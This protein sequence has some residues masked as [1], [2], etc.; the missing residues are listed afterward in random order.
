[1]HVRKVY[2]A[3]CSIILMEKLIVVARV[4]CNPKRQCCV[5][6][7]SSLHSIPSQF[8]PRHTLTTYLLQIFFN[9]IFKSMTR[10]H[11]RS[12]PVR[13]PNQK[14]VCISHLTIRVAYSPN[15]I[16]LDIFAVTIFVKEYELWICL[17]FSVF[18]HLLLP[19][20]QVWIVSPQHPIFMRVEL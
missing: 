13:F 7:N 1:M 9:V 11:V 3:P 2:L 15:L 14:Y 8:N 5:H 10:S 19:S 4:V 12:I 17:L 20:F 16:F 6:N 18:Q